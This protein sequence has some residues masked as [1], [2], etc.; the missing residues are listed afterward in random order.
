M[1]NKVSGKIEGNDVSV[2]MGDITQSSVD[3]IIVP[4]FTRCGSYGGVGGSVARS[5]AEDGM[6]A[7]DDFLSEAGEQKFGTVLLTES[8]GVDHLSFCMLCLLDRILVM[9]LILLKLLLLTR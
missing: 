2:E 5:G 7:Y 9:S 6:R 4:Q 8:G 3:A 1:A